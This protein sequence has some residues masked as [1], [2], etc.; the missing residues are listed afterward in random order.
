MLKAMNRK[1]SQVYFDPE[2]L[3]KRS[4]LSRDPTPFPKELHTKAMQWRAARD[5]HPEL[6]VSEC[7]VCS[8]IAHSLMGSRNGFF[9]T[10]AWY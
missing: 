2:V 6:E 1:S 5:I 3:D 8:V 7:S 10:K 9:K 4:K